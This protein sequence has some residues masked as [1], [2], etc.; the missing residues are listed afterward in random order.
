[1]PILAPTFEP[2]STVAAAPALPLPASPATPA[3]P[4]RPASP[5]LRAAARAVVLLGL[6]LSLAV[7]ILQLG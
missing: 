6:G 2:I 7:V 1:M 3:S 4:A 5:A